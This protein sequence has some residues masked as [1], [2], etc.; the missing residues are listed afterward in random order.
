MRSWS[1]LGALLLTACSSVSGPD[2]TRSVGVIEPRLSF[3]QTLRLPAEVTAGVP[4]T[5]TVT[6]LG[7][8]S[9]TRSDGAET[10]IDGAG[11]DIT[12]YD[13]KRTGEV[14]CTDDLG[15][16]PRDVQLTF[17]DAGDVRVR[18]LGRDFSGAPVAFAI[19]IPVRAGP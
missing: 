19:T 5:A 15:S 12:P 16:F 8:S 6:T 3:M 13:L 9:C 17:A 7:S 18:V 14:A 11:A 10:T 2:W 1:P 4:F